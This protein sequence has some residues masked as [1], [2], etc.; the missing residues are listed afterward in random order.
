MPAPIESSPTQVAVIEA[1]GT[2]L[3]TLD[4]WVT[5]RSCLPEILNAVQSG[6]LN[7]GFAAELARLPAEAQAEVFAL[8]LP[9]CRSV[10]RE[11]RALRKRPQCPRCGQPLRDRAADD[12]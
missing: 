4:R 9:A 12:G 3:S 2:R 8:G 10:A 11:L 7:V 1:Y 6:R 5:V